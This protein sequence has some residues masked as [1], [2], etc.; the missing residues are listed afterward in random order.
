MHMTY[1]WARNQAIRNPDRRAISLDTEHLTFGEI[2]TKSNQLADLL[3]QCGLEKDERVGLLMEK[4]PNAIVAMHGI[5]KA[6]GVYIPIDIHS[7]T[8][9][10]KKILAVSDV[11]MV[12]VDD[13]ARQ[14]FF[15]LK[16]E[17]SRFSSLP[18]IW[19][20]RISR[21]PNKCSNRLFGYRDLA[22]APDH[23]HAVCR[24]GS[25]TAHILFTSGSTGSPKGVEITHNNIRTFIDWS[26]DYFGI[27]PED[28]VS[29]HS[30]LHF[31][32][33]TFDIY[34]SLAAGS[35]LF[36]VD[37]SI[38][39]IPGKLSKFILDNRLTQWFSVPSL[40]SY[41][42]RFNA[43]PA[44]GFPDLERLIWCGEVFPIQSLRY[45]MEALPDVRFTNLYGP[46]EATIASSY[47]TV[48]C[49]PDTDEI[50]IGTPCKGEKLMVLD[51]ELNE[52]KSGEI[53]DLYISGAGLSPGYWK[54]TEKTMAAFQT[55]KDPAGNIVRIYKTGDLASMDEHGLFYY[56]GRSD[57]QIKS[58]GYRIELGEIENA[59]DELNIFLEFAIVSVNSSGFEGKS[60]G[61]AFVPTDHNH[62]ALPDVKQLLSEKIPSYMIPQHW[63]S[64]PLLPRNGNGKI[65]RKR[66]AENFEI[67]LQNR[68]SVFLDT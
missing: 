62:L 3:L 6:G 33:S 16:N 15:D 14:L 44:G 32:L 13:H 53:G 11:S 19:W 5:N 18:W 22:S 8:N 38:S 40:L 48:P 54:D 2:E 43:I 56:H 65:D 36:I 1:E 66:L 35:Q 25:R 41:L 51:E 37:P 29:C 61:C 28:R 46:T 26:V 23:A 68:K 12:M 17:P 60:I 4:T 45:W 20:S 49:I 63:C 24:D 21:E 39:V 57:Q 67:P 47:Y 30:P 7:P 42:A 64:Y 31:D 9:R 50:P 55:R 58:R 59:L 27:T 10:V 34:G 52:M